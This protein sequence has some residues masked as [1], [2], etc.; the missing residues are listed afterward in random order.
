MVT[1]RAHNATKHSREQLSGAPGVEAIRSGEAARIARARRAVEAQMPMKTARI[2][3]FVG[4]LAAVGAA[5]GD[6]ESTEN[7][8]QASNGRR[9]NSGGA[10]ASSAA[11]SVSA[12]ALLNRDGSADFEVTTGLLDST[13]PPP[14]AM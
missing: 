4:L 11:V 6:I 9:P 7:T 8:V 13:S 10:S 1:E 3:L 12:R 14:F 5:C 2:T